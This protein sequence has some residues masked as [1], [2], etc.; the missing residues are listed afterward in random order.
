[1]GKP[2]A[3]T[4]VIWL[5]AQAL[6][7]A[8]ACLLLL[9]PTFAAWM[10]AGLPWLPTREIVPVRAA[11]L[12][13]GLLVLLVRMALTSL[14]LLPREIGPAEAVSVGVWLGTIHF[15]IALAGIGNASPVGPVAL[16]GGAL[17]IAGSFLNSFPELQRK[18]FKQ[19]PENRGRLYTGG[20]FSLSMHINYCGD[21]IWA[22]GLA[23]MTGSIW[24]AAIPGVMTLMFV[25]FH[26]PRLDAY[27]AEKYGEEFS[28]YSRGT[29]KLIPWI[30]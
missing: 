14:V 13:A 28:A 5:L 12:S 15:G 8:V 10:G 20:L 6:T 2:A 16:T 26:I 23:M 3:V 27:L 4:T 18:R 24:S 29:R 9:S 17:F 1:M 25:F 11:L 19:R 7:T 30:Y 22:V 21:I